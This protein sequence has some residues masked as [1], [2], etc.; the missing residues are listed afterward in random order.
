MKKKTNNIQEKGQKKTTGIPE[1]AAALGV[2]VLIFGLVI[3]A[4]Y[5]GLADNEGFN[6]NKGV[7]DDY[8]APEEDSPTQ[9]ILN[10]ILD[11]VTAYPVQITDNVLLDKV[12]TAT[13]YF[14]EDGKDEAIENVLAVKVTNTSDRT[15]EYMTF[16]V[17]VNNSD[18]SFAAATVPAGK[19]VYVFNSQKK[20]APEEILSIEGKS[21]Y[22]IFFSEEPTA[23]S[24]IF[25]YQ[26]GNGTVSVMNISGN[27]IRSD[28]VVYYKSIADNGYLGGIT[29]RF[30]ITGGLRASESFNAY[31]PHAYSHMT[32]I[33]FTQYEK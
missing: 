11:E 19:S 21:Q 17:T 7:M 9:T 31:A 6:V 14:P 24:D 1:F 2:I 28:I 8:S 30:R 3:L 12:Y 23:K 33:M 20:E 22:E 25:T 5:I 16:T 32:E 4:H 10:P 26:I 29:Y 15:V 18:Y 27:D 13:G